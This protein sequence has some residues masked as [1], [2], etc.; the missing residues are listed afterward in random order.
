MERWLGRHSERI[1]ALFR[2]ALGVLFA[3]HGAQKLFG[4]FGGKVMTSSPLMLTA[5]IIELVGGLLVAVGLLA[6]WA[7]AVAAAEMVVAYFMVH[8]PRG[9]WPILNQG[10]LAALYFFSFLYVAA[11][12]SGRY[13]VDAARP[14]SRG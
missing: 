4:A 2:L 8:L 6:S 10:E 1:Y 5:G 14:R 3:F 11:R 7:A 13:G 9:P 12:G